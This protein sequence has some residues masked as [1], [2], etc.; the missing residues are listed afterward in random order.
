MPYATNK[1]MVRAKGGAAEKVVNISEVVVPDL[2]HIAMRIE[3]KE[4]R[5]KV[6]DCWHLCHDLLRNIVGS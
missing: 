3:D 1:K 5:K 4:D 2:W 6:L